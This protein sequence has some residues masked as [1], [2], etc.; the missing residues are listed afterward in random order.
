MVMK[1]LYSMQVN[2]YLYLHIPL[3]L[4]T[5]LIAGMGKSFTLYEA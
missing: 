3:L 4:G 1:G 2:S 5:Q